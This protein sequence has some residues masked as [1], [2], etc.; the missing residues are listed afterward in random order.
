M[1]SLSGTITDGSGNPVPFCSVTI[2]LAY[3]TGTFVVV[4]GANGQYTFPAS[5]PTSNYNGLPFSIT[6]SSPW[7]GT[8]S[9]AS[10][11]MQ[12]PSTGAML[13]SM[14]G[15]QVYNFTL[16]GA[17]ILNMP[18]LRMADTDWILDTGHVLEKYY[19][20]GYATGTTITY[21]RR[22]VDATVLEYFQEGLILPAAQSVVLPAYQSAVVVGDIRCA[23][24]GT[25]NEVRMEQMSGFMYRLRRTQI[26]VG[27]WFYRG[28]P[29]GTA[30]PNPYENNARVTFGIDRIM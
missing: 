24:A 17:T 25:Y 7:G 1:S 14:G 19:E 21:M 9:P 2:T 4:T 22:Y 20:I 29:F 5:G 8:F 26:T 30:M 6:P 12:N 10:V 15:A 18:G 3:N 23:S 16:T 27:A 28:T 13:T 11:L